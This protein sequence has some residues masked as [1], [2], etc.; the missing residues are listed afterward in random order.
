[1][2]RFSL[3]QTRAVKK[4]ASKAFSDYIPVTVRA[5]FIEYRRGI[6]ISGSKLLKISEVKEV[7]V[8]VDRNGRL[9][10]L[11]VGSMAFFHGDFL[12]RKKTVRPSC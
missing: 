7:K 8:L 5:Y 6:P 9:L 3:K 2:V 11:L 1:M 12:K 4:L 10:Q